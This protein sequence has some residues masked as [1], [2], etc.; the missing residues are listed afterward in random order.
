MSGIGEVREAKIK[1]RIYF[2]FPIFRLRR[3]Q[4]AIDTNTNKKK[5]KNYCEEWARVEKSFRCISKRCVFFRDLNNNIHRGVWGNEAEKCE[6]ENDKRCTHNV[7][8]ASF[9]GGHVYTHLLCLRCSLWNGWK[10]TNDNR[11]EKQ[12]M[13]TTTLKLKHIYKCMMIMINRLKRYR[14]L[15]FMCL[16]SGCTYDFTVGLGGKITGNDK[17]WKFRKIIVR[18][19][20]CNNFS[21]LTWIANQKRKVA[22]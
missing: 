17:V 16:C 19:V 21:S 4:I 5:Q 1:H 13:R 3:Y 22:L 7:Y 15:R 12:G 9:L 20:L 14:C 8:S 10:Y 18:T 6:R 11:R 2:N